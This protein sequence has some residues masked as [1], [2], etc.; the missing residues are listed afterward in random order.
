[1]SSQIYQMITDRVVTMLEAGTVPWHKGWTGGAAV[2]VN[3]VTKKEYRGFNHFFLRSACF[4]SPYWMSFKQAQERGG[5]VR[6]GE[7]GMPVIFWKR[8]EYSATNTTTGEDETRQGFILR[9][10]T[11]FNVA[12]ID[13]LNMDL[14]EV[15]RTHHEPIAEAE[16]IVAN[17]PKR[18]EIVHGQ[19]RCFYRPST[20]TVNMPEMG[21]FDQT[22][23]YYTA[24]FHELTH[25]TGHES[26]LNRRPSTEIRHFGDKEYSREE[27]VAEMGAAFLSAACG[28]EPATIE[29]SAAYLQGWLSV[30]KE[31]SKAIIHAAA[32]AQKAADFIRGISFATS[33][34][35]DEEPATT[36][37][38]AA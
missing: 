33:V 4:A 11:V 20:D 27:L 2:P 32:Q 3:A 35:T 21:L 16:A 38:A 28:I 5:K 26:R 36:I 1:M 30:L 22:E 7:K 17:M 37:Q 25:S 10:Y 8:S 31:D 15:P 19:A 24:L 13:G 34:P 18:P 12:Q 23:E 9:Y 6:K 29:N 14:P